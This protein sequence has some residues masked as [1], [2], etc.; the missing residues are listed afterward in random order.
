[1]ATD[2]SCFLA[3]LAHGQATDSDL[4]SSTWKDCWSSIACRF[5][6]ICTDSSLMMVT[7]VARVWGSACMAVS[8]LAKVKLMLNSLMR[9]HTPLFPVLIPV[10]QGPA[11]TRAPATVAPLLL[12]HNVVMLQDHPLFD[13]C[14]LNCVLS[15]CDHWLSCL[16]W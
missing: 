15:S 10:D 9:L 6:V 5:L 3:C 2:H 1:M 12:W 7:C 8:P 11:A 13:L 14:F 4:H 16:A